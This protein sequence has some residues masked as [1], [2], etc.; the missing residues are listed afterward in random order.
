MPNHLV[1]LRA[2][3]S[4]TI[5]TGH[6]FRALAL[7]KELLRKGYEVKVFSRNFDSDFLQNFINKFGQ[8][9]LP[10]TSIRDE[11]EF[12]KSIHK[13]P[14][15]LLFLDLREGP[16]YEDLVGPLS[17]HDKMPKIVFLDWFYPTRIPFDLCIQPFFRRETEKNDKILAGPQYFIFSEEMRA[18]AERY[19]RVSSAEV[20]KILI[21]M[22]GSDPCDS[23]PL[24][25]DSLCPAYDKV[26][27]TA[28]LG[29]GFASKPRFSELKHKYKNLVTI[30]SP[31]KMAPY[32]A[33]SDIAIT[34]GGLT[35]YETALFGL[36][37]LILGQTLQEEEFCREFE[38]LGTSR[39]F[40]SAQ[41]FDG[42][43]LVL[44]VGELAENFE[45]RKTMSEKGRS[46][47]DTH[48]AQRIIS[49]VEKNLY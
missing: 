3:G 11:N 37:S 5:G 42:K 24:I 31:T 49:Y 36:P 4:S 21:T 17:N 48:G 47:V 2:D 28:I 13:F 16:V 33:D 43:S 38:S 40:S 41:D 32:Y 39:Y 9:N 14:P 1:Y 35:K 34:S 23:T 12:I 46:L 7:G 10:F 45:Q 8:E 15:S 18:A 19:A 20:T 44:A 25:I 26:Q 22:G 6:L 27:F 30:D 29:P